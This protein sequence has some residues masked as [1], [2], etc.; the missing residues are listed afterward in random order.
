MAQAPTKK[1]LAQ[2]AAA[3]KLLAK[4]RARWTMN[5][6][7]PSADY[8]PEYEGPQISKQRGKFVEIPRKL[9][10]ASIRADRE[11]GPLGR[12]EHAT[13]TEKR[14]EALRKKATG[15][16]PT[17][18]EYNEFIDQLI[19]FMAPGAAGYRARRRQPRRIRRMQRVAPYRQPKFKGRAAGSLANP[20]PTKPKGEVIQGDP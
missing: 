17:G 12:S 7:H 16:K 9:L 19:M 10:D 5:P 13:Y 15:D 18:P 14:V 11:A 8:V 1:Q 4:D 20:G 2:L 6:R 3:K